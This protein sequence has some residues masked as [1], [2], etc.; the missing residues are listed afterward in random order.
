[1]VVGELIAVVIDEPAIVVYRS[2]APVPVE[3]VVVR[4]PANYALTTT[5]GILAALIRI[6]GAELRKEPYGRVSDRRVLPASTCART[7]RTFSFCAS[8]L[9]VG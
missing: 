1:M 2:E 8:R 5:A 9:R 6:S 3:D 7:P 4:Q